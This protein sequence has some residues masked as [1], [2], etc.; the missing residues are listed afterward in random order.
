M[1]L[2]LAIIT[3]DIIA[4]SNNGNITKPFQV[5][6][7]PSSFLQTQDSQLTP[8]TQKA[9]LASWQSVKSAIS[10]QSPTLCG[11]MVATFPFLFSDERGRFPL[12]KLEAISLPDRAQ[13]GA[14]MSDC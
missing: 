5:T 14:W 9:C 8:R 7:E 13:D 1:P 6:K 10:N 12:A 3:F 4:F 11:R 2:I